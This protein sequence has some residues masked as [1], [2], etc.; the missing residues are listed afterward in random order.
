M[1]SLQT[2]VNEHL[3]IDQE[4]KVFDVTVSPVGGVVAD[5]TWATTATN[6]NG[7]FTPFMDV[8]NANRIG[9]CCLI[10]QIQ[11]NGTV[12]HA[13][14]TGF[15]SFPGGYV[16][17]VML[18]Q[19]MATNGAPVSPGEI[20]DVSAG[21][22][23]FVYANTI[24]AHDGRLFRVL[25]DQSFVFDAQPFVGTVTFDYSGQAQGFNW[26]ID[27]GDYPI[28]TAFKSGSNTGT[29]SDVVTN[30]LYVLANSSTNLL[31][32]AISYRSRVLF[33]DKQ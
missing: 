9:D 17:R 30:S 15:G 10:K 8:T 7:L 25:Q 22:T 23:T 27:L 12:S 6:N 3:S 31:S 20:L 11:V 13:A 18:V 21:S 19:W 2:A 33:V 1:Q 28:E 24:I 5:N 4:L 32:P 14:A 16:V 26:T 29:I